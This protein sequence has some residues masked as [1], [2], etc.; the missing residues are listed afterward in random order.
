MKA[1]E[2]GSENFNLDEPP[3]FI[4]FPVL[5]MHP[6]TQTQSHHAAHVPECHTADWYTDA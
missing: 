2:S 1:I 4:M 3:R 5:R 6:L